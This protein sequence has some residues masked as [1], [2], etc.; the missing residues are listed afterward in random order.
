M[1]RIVRYY[2]CGPC[3]DAGMSDYHHMRLWDEPAPFCQRCGVPVSMV[4]VGNHINFVH[5]EDASKLN[6]T[7]GG[8]MEEFN[9]AKL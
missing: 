7:E 2:M 6:P 1:F 5:P 9:R 8:M 3:K 4:S